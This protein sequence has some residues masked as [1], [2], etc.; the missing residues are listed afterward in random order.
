MSQP[1]VHRLAAAESG[2]LTP[3]QRLF[4]ARIAGGSS[5]AEAARDAGYARRTAAQQASRLLRQHAIRAEVERLRAD[6]GHLQRAALDRML[7]KVERIYASA[8]RQHQCAAALRAVEMEGA[9][10]RLGA[11]SLPEGV[12]PADIWDE[13][14][15]GDAPVSLPRP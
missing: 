5:G 10:R 8:I 2:P 6:A 4:C 14:A 1:A 13:G 11:H 7:S 12:S 3:R 15:G 9:L